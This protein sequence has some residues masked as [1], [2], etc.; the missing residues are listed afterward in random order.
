[1]RRRVPDN[2]KANELVGYEPQ[3]SL[4]TTILRVAADLLARERLA[5]DAMPLAGTG[6]FRGVL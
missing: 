4:T 2:T 6:S 5:S 3:T 1:M